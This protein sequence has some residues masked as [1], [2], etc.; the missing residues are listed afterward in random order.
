MLEVYEGM[1]ADM[2]SEAYKEYLRITHELEDRKDA[3]VKLQVDAIRYLGDSIKE[4]ALQAA[5][6]KPPT[7]VNLL[8]T[9]PSDPKVKDFIDKISELK[10]QGK[11]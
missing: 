2:D 7:V 1:A 9:D 10:Q 5:T 3:R 8:I 11:L 4:L 6:T